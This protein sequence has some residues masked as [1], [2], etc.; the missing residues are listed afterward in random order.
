[1][2]SPKLE[3][4]SIAHLE[5]I[6][7]VALLNVLGEICPL[8]ATKQLLACASSEPYTVE[9][10]LELLKQQSVVTYRRLDGSY[11]V[12]E[13]SDVDLE[14][15]MKEAHRKLQMEG[16]S[17]LAS[18]IKHLPPKT[19]VARRHSLESGVHRFFNIS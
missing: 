11:R 4:L 3:I 5:L 8:R 2:P 15:R 9:Q 7:T 17:L 12:W 14:A 16:N 13:G 1:M 18:I 10:E 19:F 6:Q